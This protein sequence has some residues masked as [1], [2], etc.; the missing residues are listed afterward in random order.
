[1]IRNFQDN[2]EDFLALKYTKSQKF[3]PKTLKNKFI[4]RIYPELVLSLSRACPEFIPENYKLGLQQ[5]SG[6][7]PALEFT[8]DW[9]TLASLSGAG[10]EMLT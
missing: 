1:L 5:R 2:N 9:C 3:P 4:L 6:C 7:S 10:E 8:L